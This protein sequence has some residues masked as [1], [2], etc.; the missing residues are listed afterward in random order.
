MTRSA[1]GESSIYQDKSGRWHGF[2]S[3]GLRTGGGRDRR[4][5]SGPRRSDVV[6]RVR[7]LEQRRDAGSAG[8]AGRSYTVG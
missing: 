3:M 2:V 7:D 8:V 1:S 5:V 4:H 6:G